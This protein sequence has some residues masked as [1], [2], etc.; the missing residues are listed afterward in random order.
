MRQGHRVNQEQLSLF[1]RER[2]D[3]YSENLQ[4]DFSVGVCRTCV[5]Y[6]CT[7]LCCP[8]SYRIK[9]TEETTFKNKNKK[10]KSVYE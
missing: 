10:K 9:N 5:V 2:R 3:F 7:C 6:F 8:W 1:N 4:K